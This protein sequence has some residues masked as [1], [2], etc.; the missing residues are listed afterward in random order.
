MM[1]SLDLG[2]ETKHSHVVFFGELKT[3]YSFVPVT[4]SSSWGGT[5]LGWTVRTSTD[6]CE[7]GKKKTEK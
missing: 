5:I 1:L 2:F 4:E 3:F 7:K 6:N